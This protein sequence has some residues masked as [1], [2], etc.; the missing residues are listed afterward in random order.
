MAALIIPV[1]AGSSVAY[2]GVKMYNGSQ[3]YTPDPKSVRMSRY[4]YAKYSI[5]NPL[6]DSNPT[7]SSGNTAGDLSRTD[8]LGPGGSR[9]VTYGPA[10]KNVNTGDALAYN[11]QYYKDD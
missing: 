8:Y 11:T 5:T 3:G 6:A 2:T 9:I 4:P 10:Y 7:V 1:I